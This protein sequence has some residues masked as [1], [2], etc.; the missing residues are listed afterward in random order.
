ME[1]KSVEEFYNEDHPRCAFCT[2]FE[3]KIDSATT[4]P[5]AS[6][7]IEKLGKLEKQNIINELLALVANNST[8]SEEVAEQF[9]DNIKYQITEYVLKHEFN[10]DHNLSV[11]LTLWLDKCRN[12]DSFEALQE[13]VINTYLKPQELPFKF[14]KL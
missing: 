5:K 9:F 12:P 10:S 2:G 7:V 8:L 3:Q 6:P 11:Q 13:M 1:I 14:K 4:D